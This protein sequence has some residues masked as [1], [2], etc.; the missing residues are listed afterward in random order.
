MYQL[1]YS[2]RMRA[3]L[4]HTPET[5][6]RRLSASE[7]APAW[8]VLGCGGKPEHDPCSPSSLRTWT[9]G[10]AHRDSRTDA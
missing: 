8:I 4:Q 7:T 5:Y 1:Q 10:S 6:T 3:T 9:N 2:E